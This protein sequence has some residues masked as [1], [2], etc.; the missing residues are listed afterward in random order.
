MAKGRQTYGGCKKNMARVLETDAMNG[1]R[2]LNQSKPKAWPAK[3]PGPRAAG[4][5]EGVADAFPAGPAFAPAAEL[6]SPRHK[7]SRGALSNASGRFEKETRF[8]DDDGWDLPEDLPPL[9]TQ[10][11]REPAKT[12]ITRNDSPDISFDQSINPYR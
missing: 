2:R 12:I 9:R 4:P 1:V 7:G 6:P 11:T 5:G 3:G 8:H 10:V